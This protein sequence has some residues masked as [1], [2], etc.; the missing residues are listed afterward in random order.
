M[1][2]SHVSTVPLN[3]DTSSVSMIN[4][5][6]NIATML[7][8]V[9]HSCLKNIKLARFGASLSVH[10]VNI[11]QMR[12]INWNHRKISKATNVISISS[13]PIPYEILCPRE[14]GDIFLCMPIVFQE[15]KK[16]QKPFRH[17]LI[18]MLI[19]GILHL[20]GYDHTNDHDENIMLNKEIQ[21][22]SLFGIEHEIIN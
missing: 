18:R 3:Y 9:T 15:S 8:F 21:L 5:P 4:F 10:S 12:C 19:H 7:E 13:D 16:Y 20:V 2:N 1:K 22:L 14:L 6:A 11:K 17:Y